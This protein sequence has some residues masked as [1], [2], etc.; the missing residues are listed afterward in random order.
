MM[1]LRTK[2]HAID[3]DDN[4]N[5]A[6][7]RVNVLAIDAEAYSSVLNSN[8]LNCQLVNDVENIGLQCNNKYN[9][10]QTISI[11]FKQTKMQVQQ[12][13]ISLETEGGGVGGGKRSNC[14]VTT[15]EQQYRKRS[16]AHR[17]PSKMQL[18]ALFVVCLVTFSA[19][20]AVARPNVDRN[21]NSDT[22]SQNVAL[23]SENN[24]SRLPFNRFA[25]DIHWKID[26]NNSLANSK[27]C[28]YE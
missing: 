27:F 11:N 8:Q 12:Y 7:N 15:H 23:A 6:S 26:R 19:Q 14:S 5:D 20:S 17:Y 16:N 9:N 13:T 25:I 28:I 22:N 2:R 24:V 21:S 18:I 1:L 10:G 4:D 3:N